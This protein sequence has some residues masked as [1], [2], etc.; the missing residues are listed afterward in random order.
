MHKNF[1][2]LAEYVRKSFRKPRAFS[3]FPL[4]PLSLFPVFFL[5]SLSNIVCPLSHVSVTLS[6]VLWVCDEIVSAYAQQAMKSFS[7]KL[8]QRIKVPK[9]L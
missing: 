1:S 4:F 5:P 2:S 8:S 7:G 6:P 3:V 9:K